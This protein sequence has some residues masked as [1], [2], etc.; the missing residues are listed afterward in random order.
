[1]RI[2]IVSDLH[3]DINKTMQFGFIDKINEVD[4]VLIAGDIAGHYSK[5]MVFLQSLKTDTPI[6]VVAGNH[7]GYDYYQ[8]N[9]PLNSRDGTVE[10]SIKTLQELPK[11]IYYLH[12][13]WL[14][15]RDYV[16]YGGTMYTDFNLYETPK[17]SM[18]YAQKG[19]NDFYYVKTYDLAEENVRTVTP[20]DY[21]NWHNNFMKGLEHIIQNT[22]KNI[23][24]LSHFNPS[25]KCINKK[26]LEGR[27]MKLNPAYTSNLDDF[28]LNNPKIKYWISGHTHCGYDFKIGQC[29]LICEP[30]GYYGYD[31]TSV[32]AKYFGKII[33]I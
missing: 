16:I 21:I 24:V 8:V 23:I 12:N 29:R 13:K 4:L 1:M 31:S 2:L 30:Y 7:L 6:I 27:L 28:I 32:P 10:Y 18:Q 33:E 11:P 20:Q 3:I 26:Y 25:K 14:G 19:L 15:I 9:E 5:E 22:D 17:E